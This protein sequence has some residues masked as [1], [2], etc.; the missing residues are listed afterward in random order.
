MA[1]LTEKIARYQEVLLSILEQE[2]DTFPLQPELEDQIIADTVRNH[3]QLVRTGW[4]KGSRIHE[5]LLQFD[6]K[7]SGKIWIQANLTELHVED[8]LMKRRVP[9]SDIVLGVQP[10][11]YRQFTSFAMA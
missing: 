11:E 2:A 1:E 7:P 3:F 9:A 10:P 6:I 4:V 8:E 5:V